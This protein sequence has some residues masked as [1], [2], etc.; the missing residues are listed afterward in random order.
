MTRPLD[1]SRQ[2]EP[3]AVPTALITGSTNTHTKGDPVEHGSRHIN[4]AP[5]RCS[6]AIAAALALALGAGVLT[7]CG[8]GS[9]KPASGPTAGSSTIPAAEKGC[10]QRG[11]A[12]TVALEADWHP[13][14]PFVGG[15]ALDDGS[16]ESA[17][18]DT[19]LSV[20]PSGQVGPELASGYT[21]SSDGLTYILQLRQGVT[22]Q[23]GTPFN[24]QAV[25]FNFQRDL[26]PAQK[27]IFYS[28]I[29]PIKS[30]S[31][32][33]PYTV[34]IQ[35]K[36]PYPA[37]PVELAG[38]PGMMVS[39]TAV[40]KYGSSYPLHPVG[41]G[42]FEFVSQ[43]AGQSVSFKRFPGYWQ[44][45]YPCLD[46]LTFESI[47]NGSSRISSLQSGTVQDAENLAFAQ[48]QQAKSAAGVDLVRIPGLG[49]VFQMLETQ[50]APFNNVLARQAVLYATNFAAINKA[51][52]DNIYTP[53][54]SSFPPSSWAYPGPHVPG[55][56]EYDLA[57]AKQ[58]VKQLGGLSFTLDIQSGSPDILQF[59]EALASQWEQ[60]GMHVTIAQQDQ[61]TLIDNATNGNFQAMG[62]RWQGSFDPSLDVNEF[63]HT[64]A[65]LNN[66]H[67]SDP[68]LDTLLDQATTADGQAARKS[69]YAQVAQRIAYDAPYDYLYAADWFRAM[70]PKLHGVPPLGNNWFVATK[71]WL[72][73]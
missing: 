54:E 15:L 52:Y 62:F 35:L 34:Q 61:V 72:A 71:T 19:L 18:Y 13:L 1:T 55:Y 3:R 45:G 40:Q 29:S 64:G 28:F 43:V 48:V 17:V 25:V 32:T 51:L 9:T 10:P 53:V 41:A 36:N 49:T 31:A 38:F 16:V 7:G 33:G 5:V 6:G 59:N 8:A 4:S 44:Q 14:D 2:D 60:A 37:L 58:L 26:N 56:P 68:T 24:A 73:A 39:P 12:L 65:S 30:V 11:G 69:L 22:F 27:A 70:S 46:S 21:V 50:H 66:V 20:S 23:D 57:K 42:P 63:F 47:P 67:L